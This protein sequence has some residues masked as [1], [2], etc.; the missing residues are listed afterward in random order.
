ME[1]SNY[2]LEDRSAEYIGKMILN[3]SENIDLI[4][5]QLKED[6]NWIEDNITGEIT[7]STLLRL[8]RK[9]FDGNDY[10]VLLTC[11]IDIIPETA[12]DDLV[13]EEILSY[14]DEDARLKMLVSLAHKRLSE[15]QLQS[16]CRQGFSFECYF[17]L[18]ILYYV[19]SKYP[20]QLLKD[21]VEDS[22]LHCSYSYMMEEL[23]D[24]LIRTHSASDE[25]KREYIEG[26]RVGLEWKRQQ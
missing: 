23:V 25:M 7:K 4:L 2:S 11:I 6:P 8:L 17:E 9:N 21:F 3:N 20:L 13:F 5:E 15:R 10:D 18:A 1:L 16:L 26:I 19:E 12:V 24:E 14:P 22:F